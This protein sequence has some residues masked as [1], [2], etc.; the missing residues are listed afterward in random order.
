MEASASHLIFD[1]IYQFQ[2]DEFNLYK[3]MTGGG[4]MGKEKLK[5]AKLKKAA[6]I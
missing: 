5:E 3:H 6:D 1:N 2:S 4:I